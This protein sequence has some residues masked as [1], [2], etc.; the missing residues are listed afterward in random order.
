VLGE[1]RKPEHCKKA[2]VGAGT[3]LSPRVGS[4][5]GNIQRQ[6]GKEVKKK[7]PQKNGSGD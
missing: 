1:K 2:S 5:L 4:G 7:H 3:P 6:G